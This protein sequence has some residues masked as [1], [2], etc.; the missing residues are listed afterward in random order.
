MGGNMWVAVWVLWWAAVALVLRG[1][2]G[3]LCR[4]GSQVCANG[5]IAGGDCVGGL[6]CG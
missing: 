1:P 5:G 2:M 6:W 3:H 4:E